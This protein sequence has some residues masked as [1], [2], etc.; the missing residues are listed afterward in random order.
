MVTLFNGSTVT[1]GQ[2]SSQLAFAQGAVQL[3][4]S[5]KSSQVA[6]AAN[7]GVQPEDKQV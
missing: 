6:G 2:Q 4:S 1:Q 5:E 3:Q 7:Q